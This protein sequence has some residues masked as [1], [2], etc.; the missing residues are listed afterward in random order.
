MWRVAS[1][2]V[3]EFGCLR[4]SLSAHV[5]VECKFRFSEDTEQ[6]VR[7]AAAA[8]GGHSLGS[9]QFTDVYWDVPGSYL[10]T[11]RDFWLRQRNAE[12]ELKVPLSFDAQH[13]SVDVYDEVHGLDK[14]LAH[15][16][17]LDFLGGEEQQSC[18]PFGR[19]GLKEF[20]K[21]ST[22]RT[23]YLVSF[24]KDV[25]VRVDLDR[26]GAYK[27]GECELILQEQDSVSISRASHTLEEFCRE[28]ALDTT[29]PIRGKVLEFISVNSPHHYKMLE[30]CGLIQRKLMRSVT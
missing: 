13:A 24:G 10:L 9:K 14:V 12:W 26:A 28:F 18:H 21:I 15:L 23:S 25:S 7:A 1:R 2:K 3:Q 17:K 6:K 20:A 29:P 22:F 4:R 11:C 19:F 16:E 8:A 27:I 5:E 30:Q